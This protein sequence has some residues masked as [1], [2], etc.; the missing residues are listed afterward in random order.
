MERVL[1]QKFLDETRVILLTQK[2]LLLWNFQTEEI[3]TE[4]LQQCR[5]FDIVDR[6]TLIFIKNRQLAYV[7]IKTKEVT[8]IMPVDEFDDI[9][10][11][12][13]ID[14]TKVAIVHEDNDN[15]SWSICNLEKKEI[16][17]KLGRIDTIMQRPITVRG[18]QVFWHYDN[19]IHVYDVATMSVINKIETTCNTSQLSCDL[20]VF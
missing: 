3:G 11:L 6:N 19:K 18:L 12:K 5:V 13:C 10:H 7:K 20:A 17:R 1:E 9:I 8:E 2:A 14:S 16:S 4:L 15:W